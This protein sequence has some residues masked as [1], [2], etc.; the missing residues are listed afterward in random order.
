[1]SNQCDAQQ[2]SE[3]TVSD[4]HG[5]V[6]STDGTRLFYRFWLATEQSIDS[7][8]VLVLHGIGNH[9]APYK[10]IAESFNR[11]GIDV[12]ALDARG[13]GLSCGQR[14]R[15]PSAPT[16]CADIEAIIGEIRQSRPGVRLY[17]LGDS[18][19]GV[20]ALCYA[21]CDGCDLSGLILMAPAIN[22]APTQYF[23]TNNI[24]LLPYLLFLRRTPALN[25][26]GE[27]LEKGC[28][29]TDFIERRRKDFLAYKKV[30]M[31]YLIGI[32]KLVKGWKSKMAPRINVPS[33][34]IHGGRDSIISPRGSRELFNS[35]GSKDKQLCI[36]DE[37]N[38]TILW[39]P[40]T[41]RILDDVASWIL[42]H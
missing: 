36:Y 42:K 6:L 26:V 25:L 18:M 7:R 35:L 3:A 5:S 13:H 19:G 39:D 24:R 8:V 31:E 32:G 21:A 2:F 4:P 22:V 15:I 14:N 28:R 33:L 12:Y 38:H 29:D 30:S 34:I 16:I 41:P 11:C 23:K 1:M 40:E 27:R 20:F 37:V 10:V 9:G 17:L